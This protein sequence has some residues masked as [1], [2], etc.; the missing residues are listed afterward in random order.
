VAV[1]V[2]ELFGIGRRLWSILI[3]KIDILARK[4]PQLFL[5][6]GIFGAVRARTF[7]YRDGM[8]SAEIAT[9]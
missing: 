7:N 9:R 2:S 8:E 5:T 6:A 1:S 3:P 4:P